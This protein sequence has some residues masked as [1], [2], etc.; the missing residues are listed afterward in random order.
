MCTGKN[1]DV[2]LKQFQHCGDTQ[3]MRLFLKKVDP[4]D[5]CPEAREIEGGKESD[6]SCREQFRTEIKAIIRSI[7]S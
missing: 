3:Q 5:E 4:C 2:A 1:I 6:C 7:R